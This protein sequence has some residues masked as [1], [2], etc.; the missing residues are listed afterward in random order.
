MCDVSGSMSWLP[1]DISVSL[2]VYLSERNKS[3][4]KDAFIT[5]TSNPTMQYLQGTA[6]QRFNQISWA[7]GYDT[8][9]QKAFELVLNTAKRNNDPDV[10]WL[11]NYE[12]IKQQYEIAWYK[13][14][15]LVFWNVNGR[16]WNVPVNMNQEWVALIS[17][18][19]PAIMKWLLWWEDFTPIWIMLKTLNSERYKNII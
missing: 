6:C 13:M 18:A 15:R 9:L 8:N 7:V 17:W 16:E 11:T 19:S 12:A 10:W 2:W 1:M 3:V 5:F 14:P 4:F